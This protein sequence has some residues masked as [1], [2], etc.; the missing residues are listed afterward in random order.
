MWS[1][2]VSTFCH[3]KKTFLVPPP[4]TPVYFTKSIKL[5]NIRRLKNDSRDKKKNRKHARH[6]CCCRSLPKSMPALFYGALS[7]VTVTPAATRSGNRCSI[8]L[9]NLCS[10]KANQFVSIF[11]ATDSVLQEDRK[12]GGGGKKKRKATSANSFV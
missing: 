3:P 1:L 8:T 4:A 2:K 7:S 5:I 11:S 6:R 10:K 9:R 12:K